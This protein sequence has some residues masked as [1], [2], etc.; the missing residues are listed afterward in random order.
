[1]PLKQQRSRKYT[2][3]VLQKTLCYTCNNEEKYTYVFDVNE[4]SYCDFEIS[5][6]DKSEYN[7]EVDFHR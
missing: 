5:F 3:L 1:M 2:T 4:S 6:Q 7:V